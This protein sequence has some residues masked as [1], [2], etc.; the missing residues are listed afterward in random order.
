MDYMDA[1]DW[2]SGTWNARGT[3]GNRAKTVDVSPCL[4]PFALL[5]RNVA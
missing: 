5:T 4:R 3:Q 1:M 2:E